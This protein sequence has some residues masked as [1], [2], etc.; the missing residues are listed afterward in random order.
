M[1]PTV[2]M[3]NLAETK[4]D[5]RVRR[6]AGTIASAG[7][8]VVV[9]GPAWEQQER[10]EALDNF[11]L[12]RVEAPNQAQARQMVALEEADQALA[13]TV[14]HIYPQLMEREFKRPSTVPYLAYR[15]LRKLTKSAAEHLPPAGAP[16]VARADR[17]LDELAPWFADRP[18][19]HR[20][21]S[22]LLTNVRLF[23][24]ALPLRGDVVHANDLDTLPASVMLKR[25]WNVPL[26]YDAHE[27]YAEQFA[28]ADRHPTWHRYYTELE[29]AL[30]PHTDGR[31]TVCDALGDYF[32][33]ERG[34]RPFVTIRN[35][36]SRALLPG[37][38]MLERQNS[39]RKLIYHGNYFKSRGLD[40]IIRAARHVPEAH[41]VFRGFGDHEPA[42]RALAEQEGV[43]GRT[44]EFAPPVPVND[45][46]RTAAD[47][48][49][50]LCPFVPTSLNMSYALPNK[51]FEYMMSG[52]ALA[53]SDLVEMR[54]LVD[55][56]DVGVVL[57]SLEP[58]PLGQALRAILADPEALQARRRRAYAAARDEYHW[59]HEAERLR[60]YYAPFLASR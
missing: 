4:R 18:V 33:R 27:I 23:R 30:L 38:E 41:F 19:I 3:L 10:Y 44:V 42:L 59:E 14:R 35:M 8:R 12:M 39:P 55:K 21:R 22:L 40:E 6:I 46:V 50:G 60:A 52:L 26:V 49:I 53:I 15:R 58:E 36:P 57:P 11:E 31:M 47:C 45:L 51:F 28:V 24:A 2:V 32:V 29:R 13:A 48:D 5:P 9:V 56:L 16:L 34:S 54:N 25:A 17:V 1:S 20:I 43:L 7:A 37:A